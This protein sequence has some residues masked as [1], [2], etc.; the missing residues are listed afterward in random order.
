[1][2]LRGSGAS[3]G[4]RVFVSLVYLFWTQVGLVPGLI[5]RRSI[6]VVEDRSDW[7]RR[8]ARSFSPPTADYRDSSQS[9]FASL[10]WVWD[11]S[12]GLN[13][14]HWA[15]SMAATH[16]EYRGYLR[17]SVDMEAGQHRFQPVQSSES[18]Y[19]PL[20]FGTLAVMGLLQVA[21]SVAILLHLTGYLQEVGSVRNRREL[22]FC[23][24]SGAQGDVRLK[25]NLQ[26][27]PSSLLGNERD[28]KVRQYLCALSKPQSSN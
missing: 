17:N 5:S 3:G 4:S 8:E 27:L 13:G 9:H 7:L 26:T 22:Y 23:F 10:H 16:S 24:Y 28:Q 19:R 11:L 25:I 2:C 14:T 15:R 6:R 21:S 20:L 1:M 12:P 18:T